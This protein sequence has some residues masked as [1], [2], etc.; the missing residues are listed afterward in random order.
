MQRG[1]T[2]VFFDNSNI[3]QGQ[4][5]A[6][7]RIDAKKLQALL[8]KDGQVWQVFFF[9]SVTDP[10][11]YQQTAFY[12]FLKGEMHWEVSLFSLGKKTIKCRRCGESSTTAVEKGVDVALATKMLTLSN[13]RAY[14]TALLVGADR[15]YLETVRAIKGAGQRVEIFAWKGTISEQMINESSAPVVYFDDHRAK[16][17]RTE[18]IDTDAEGL[19]KVE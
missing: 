13:A 14:E 11:R 4:Q 12:K 16:L 7:W 17:E 19:S 15:D 5:H 1:K 2:I 9:A 10:P 6:G 18:E 3:F 8:D